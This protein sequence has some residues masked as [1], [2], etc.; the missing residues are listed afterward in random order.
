MQLVGKNLVNPAQLVHKCLTFKTSVGKISAGLDININLPNPPKFC[1]IRYVLNSKVL[2]AL[3]WIYSLHW[4]GMIHG[5]HIY[6]DM[7]LHSFYGRNSSC[8][9]RSR[10]AFVLRKSKGLQL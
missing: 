10:Q 2:G 3:P 9:A 7:Y 1:A 6:E 4:D 8:A 5:H